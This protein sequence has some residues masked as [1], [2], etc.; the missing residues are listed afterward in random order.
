[1]KKGVFYSVL[2]IIILVPVIALSSV[3]SETLRGYGVDIGSNVRLK[4]G[5]YFL[6]S[7]NE[8]FERAVRIVGRRS[9]T[10]CINH[11][12][13]EGEGLDSAED[14]ILELFENR[15]IN[16][17]VSEIMDYSIYDWMNRSDDVAIKRGFVL[18]REIRSVDVSMGDPWNVMFS[19]EMHVKLKDRQNLFSYE[20]NLTK[21]VYVPIDDLEDPLY[22]IETDGRVARKV[23][24]HDGNL[25]ERVL[26][27]S[28]GN[29]WASGVSVKTGD[30]GS[31]SGKDEKILVIEN[32]DSSFSSFAGV[33]AGSNTTSLGTA[34][35]L[36]SGWDSVA[37]NT[38]MVVEGSEGEV[39]EIE[40]LYSLHQNRLYIEGEGPS[41]LDRLEGKLTNSYPDAGLESLVNKG[42]HE[43]TGSYYEERSNVDYIYFNGSSNNYIVK[44]MPSKFRLDETHLA[45]YGVDN[46]LS[47]S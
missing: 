24:K 47:Y 2:T 43:G 27:G 34:Y 28:G 18:E 46:T 5:L 26:T 7:V 38:R 29:G 23:H 11:I 15:T 20:K 21:N 41:F 9:L 36:D 42:D 1:M 6:D 35:V 10:A 4:S 8:D 14:T 12:V 25:T 44:G 13:N 16:G 19:L 45:R 37:N 22:T 17:T 40:N 3:Y 33:V 30:P 31:V 32:A 39:W